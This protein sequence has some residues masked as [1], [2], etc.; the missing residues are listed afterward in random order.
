MEFV[1]FRP[2]L[3]YEEVSIS[4]RYKAQHDGGGAEPMPKP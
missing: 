2:F 3:V 1:S 4:H